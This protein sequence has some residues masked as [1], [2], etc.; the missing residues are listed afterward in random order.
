MNFYTLPHQE[1][2]YKNTLPVDINFAK[3]L[4]IFVPG[5][6]VY[7]FLYSPLVSHP[8]EYFD[9]FPGW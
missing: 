5:G 4:K 1:V 2:R 7:L 3:F 6:K 8:G 9:T